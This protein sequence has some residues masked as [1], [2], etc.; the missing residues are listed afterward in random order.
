MFSVEC[1][2]PHLRQAV[3][4][5]LIAAENILR[6]AEK[7]VIT[8]AEID[9]DCDGKDE[10]ILNTNKFAAVFKPSVGGMLVEL[11]SYDKAFNLTDTLKRRREGYH[12]KLAK[13]QL[14][15]KE[16][17]ESKTD[18]KT[19]SIHDLVLT[20]ELGLE[21]LLA[22]D[23]Y[24]R[25]CFIDHF[26]TRDTDIQNFLTGQFGEEGDF[27][28]GGYRSYGSVDKGIIAFKR[29]GH[30]WRPQRA[31]ALTVEKRFYFA[32]DSDVISVNYTLIAENDDLYDVR[33]AVENNF[34]FQ[35]GH[36]H[37]RY[38]LFN[39]ARV[40]GSYLDSLI[41]Q[42]NCRNVALYDDWRKIAVAL[43]CDLDCTV[44]QVPIYTISLS[45]GGF[46]KVYQGTSLINI[47]HLA[48]KRGIP[49]ELT[50]L[51]F[52]GRTENMPNR[53]SAARAGAMA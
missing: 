12:S 22:D 3:Y 23:W 49:T 24:L 40:E 18:D 4:E 1:T 39:G 38:P 16:I 5:N 52:A 48:L 41:S 25:R 37:D 14:D 35:A 17:T 10:V 53:F 44:W 29:T 31:Q 15:K 33:L 43:T 8:R 13:A 51:L 45:E 19:A 36:V 9:Y 46:E 27:V 32:P 28:L 11:D 20:K 34:N 21:K 26:L 30:L 47:F 7:P 6:K 42:L 50:F 2:L